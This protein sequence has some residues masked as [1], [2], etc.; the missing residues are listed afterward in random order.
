MN[1]LQ[2][3]SK[4]TMTNALNQTIGKAFLKALKCKPLGS[5]RIGSRY[6]INCTHNPDVSLPSNLAHATALMYQVQRFFDGLSAKCTRSIQKLRL[7]LDAGTSPDPDVIASAVDMVVKN[8]GSLDQA[9]FDFPAPA[10]GSQISGSTSI[11][12]IVASLKRLE[13]HLPQGRRLSTEALSASHPDLCARWTAARRKWN[14]L[15]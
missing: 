6:H 1:T 10:D 11:N 3:Q 2:I 8:F 13:N 7:Q 9:A 4:E 15:I 5:M 12:R 14:D